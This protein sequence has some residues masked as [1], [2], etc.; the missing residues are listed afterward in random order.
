MK[1]LIAALAT[2]ALVP[3]AHAAEKGADFSHNAEFRVRHQME[4]NPTGD[5][6]A[7]GT[8]NTTVQRF[9]LGTMFRASEKFSATL[10]LLHNA[11][12]GSNDLYLRDPNGYPAGSGDQGRGLLNGTK[13]A[14]NVLL[15]QEAYG[16]WNVNDE[17]SLR[18]GRGSFTMA[19][20]SVIATNDWEASPFSFEGVMG[21]YEMEMGRL[22]GWAVKFAEYSRGA[23]SGVT[24]P[25]TPSNPPTAGSGTNVSDPEAN[26]YGL[27]F[28][29]K[30]MPA[31]LKM[32]NLHVIK[33]QK[34][35]T[36]DTAP[37][38]AASAFGQDIMRYG[39]TVSGDMAH[40]D[41]RVTYAAQSGDLSSFTA[42][43]VKTEGN[44]MH[45]EVGYTM[46]DFMNS[47]VSFTYHTDTGNKAS[48]TK[49]EAYDSY[50]YERHA[51][52]GLMDIVDWGN[53][54]YMSVGYSLM[55]MDQMDIGLQYH[56]FTR[57]EKT[58]GN[59]AGI[60]GPT[61]LATATDT[62][63]DDLG[64]EVDL[65]ATKKYDSGFAIQARYGM[66]MPGKAFKL[67][68][69]GKDDTISQLFVE[70]KMNF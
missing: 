10:T 16:T 52:A 55:P 60:N 2:L 68:N 31:W 44:M 25:T 56:M 33:T 3:V 6:D 58:S 27:S 35:I 45:G 59:N 37:T 70:A 15:V 57:T 9:K 54:T 69:G 63:K 23:N 43:K 26:A 7:Q 61:S 19:D 62:T 21:T 12:W 24:L 38:S 49:N 42:A 41:Y 46:P 64:S 1:N 50:F 32:V 53:L 36:P 17:F 22:T 66:F 8:V 34:S 40:V 47:R 13:D 29:L 48:T 30:T 28:D 65:V 51:N 14:D 39:V 67:N 11:S 18:F 4:Q 5:K 20:G